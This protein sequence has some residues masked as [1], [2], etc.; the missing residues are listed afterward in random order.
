MFQC[1]ICNTN[2][3][4]VS[5]DSRQEWYTEVYTCPECG[6][7]HEH[8]REFQAQSSLIASDRLYC[9]DAEGYEISEED[10]E[11]MLYGDD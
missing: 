9:I 3:D 10:A 7:H 1:L 2:L 6:T 5:D 8:R 4:F 11:K